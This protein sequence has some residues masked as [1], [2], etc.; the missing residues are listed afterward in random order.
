M[1]V[2]MDEPERISLTFRCADGRKRGTPDELLDSWVPNYWVVGGAEE[3]EDYVACPDCMKK[4]LRQDANTE[5]VLA[6]ELYERPAQPTCLLNGDPQPA[7]WR[8]SALSRIAVGEI[9]ATVM[10]CMTDALRLNQSRRS[11]PPMTRGV[12]FRFARRLGAPV[13]QRRFAG[14]KIVF[15]LT[16]LD[17]IDQRDR[18]LPKLLQVVRCAA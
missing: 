4:H 15:A 11:V 18:L 13:A 12:A 8:L 1:V 9:T 10:G 16:S 17:L 7:G 3:R 2:I 6:Q 5:F 14:G